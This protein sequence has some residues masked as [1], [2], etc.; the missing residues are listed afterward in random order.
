MMQFL[1]IFHL[2][3]S[4]FH[5]SLATL[6]I[7]YRLCSSVFLIMFDTDEKVLDLIEE[8]RKRPILWDPQNAHYYKTPL[9]LDAWW[10]ISSVFGFNDTKISV[11]T[12]KKKIESILASF[13]REKQKEKIL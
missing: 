8:Y 11:E 4:H 1:I 13:R 2:A 6:L 10:E 12:C 9:K 5:I 7:H 3:P